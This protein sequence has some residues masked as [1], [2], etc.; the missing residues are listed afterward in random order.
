[1]PWNTP[2]SRRLKLWAMLNEQRRNGAW[3][4]WPDKGNGLRGFHKRMRAV[5][6]AHVRAG[7]GTGQELVLQGTTNL[8]SWVPVQT[9]VLTAPLWHSRMLRP[10]V[11]GRGTTV[12]WARTEP[13][14]RPQ[15]VKVH[16][17]SE[18]VVKQAHCCPTALARF[19]L[20]RRYP[21][22]KTAKPKAHQ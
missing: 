19:P 16:P 2:L 17:A 21:T 22:I 20:S 18:N 13:N 14:Q 5:V 6:S 8:S 7:A 1:M 9:N 4:P 12:S 3:R 11:F 15:H 10:A